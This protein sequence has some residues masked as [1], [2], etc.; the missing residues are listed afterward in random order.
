MELNSKL[1]LL[2]VTNKRTWRKEEVKIPFFYK[3]TYISYKEISHNY[4]LFLLNYSQFYEPFEEYYKDIKS[5]CENQKIPLIEKNKFFEN[6]FKNIFQNLK[7]E[8]ETDILSIINLVWLGYCSNKIILSPDRAIKL[9]TNK[10][11]YYGYN[12]ENIEGYL[13]RDVISYIYELKKAS[14]ISLKAKYK[15]FNEKGYLQYLKVL[16][17]NYFC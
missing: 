17:E 14:Y 7:I 4:G 12:K 10:L 1:I 3:Y 13:L 2:S 15:F 8:K 16:E 6:E 5:F 11:E 9:L